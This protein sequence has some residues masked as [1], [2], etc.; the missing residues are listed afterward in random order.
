ML[1]RLEICSANSLERGCAKSWTSN[2]LRLA[3]SNEFMNGYFDMNHMT[4]IEAKDHHNESNSVCYI[5]Y[6]SIHRKNSHTITL[7]N[8]FNASFKTSNGLSV[9][10]TMYEGP[11]LQT[12]IF[13]I[14]TNSQCYMFIYADK[15]ITKI[16][17]QML[18]INHN[19]DKLRIIW[20]SNHE[21]R[22]NTETYG[23]YATL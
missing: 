23:S 14:F 9:N 16:F 21:F 5:T 4:E 3:K 11:E 8:V 18:V 19:R 22:L 2:P 12:R 7:I 20:R 10:D 1:K 6:L 15:H 17:R 13:D